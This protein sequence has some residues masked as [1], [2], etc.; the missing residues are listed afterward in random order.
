MP[1]PPAARLNEQSPGAFRA[2]LFAAA[3]FAVGCF[4]GSIVA[5]RLWPPAVAALDGER[6]KTAFDAYAASL[7]R[8]QGD[9]PNWCALKNEWETYLTVLGEMKEADSCAECRKI[10]E[11]NRDIVATRCPTAGDA[12]GL[13]FFD[14]PKPPDELF[15]IVPE[16]LLK[17]YPVGR[18][19][20][21]V[22]VFKVQGKGTAKDWGLRQNS[23]FVAQYE[24]VAETKIEKNDGKEISAVFSLPRVAK[25]VYFSEEEFV[26][27]WPESP[28]LDLAWEQV[29][30][31]APFLAATRDI[32]N[33]IDLVDP[34]QKRLLSFLVPKLKNQSA[35]KTA[36]VTII[37]DPES[38]SG[39]KFRL[40]Y[41][42]GWGPTE[43]EIL[44]GQTLDRRTLMQVA[45]VLTLFMDYHIFPD[46]GKKEGDNWKVPASQLGALLP[47]SLRFKAEG[48]LEVNLK[49]LDA[50]KKIANL[51]IV[52]G[53]LKLVGRRPLL[54]QEFEISTKKGHMKFSTAGLAL[55]SARIEFDFKGR[56]EGLGHLF[57]PMEGSR[58]VS[59][60][61]I[62]EGKLEGP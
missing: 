13:I 4:L 39:C 22:S 54:R 50:E 58:D 34:K 55:Q 5:G 40:G 24:I 46:S 16:E 8:L 48:E 47:P 53:D 14:K 21:S 27:D 59:I 35:A 1:N 10:A 31:R 60:Q 36:S 26:R 49:K 25:V 43:I 41:R 51:E 38:F 9:Q 56:V 44:E 20:K 15:K 18:T 23:A 29:G 37:N 28:I 62:Y 11:L 57:F 12:K 45:D 3:T 52:K 7:Q 19:L 32:G 42:I 17:Y 33:L 2:V 61:T 30:K 6:S